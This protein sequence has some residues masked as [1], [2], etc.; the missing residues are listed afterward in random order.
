MGDYTIHTYRV[1]CECPYCQQIRKEQLK[2]IGFDERKLNNQKLYKNVRQDVESNN[3]IT[4][5]NPLTQEPITVGGNT[6]YVPKQLGPKK[7]EFR[8]V[9]ITT[10]RNN[11]FPS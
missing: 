9:W 10:V 8:G 5:T 4:L 6:V 1:T 3:F 7:R 11:D 2:Q